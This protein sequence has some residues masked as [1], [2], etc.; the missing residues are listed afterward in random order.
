[1]ELEP[2]VDDEEGGDAEPSLG[3]FDQMRDQSKAWQQ[4]SV[5]AYP[6]DD[7]EQDDA[8]AEP[9]LGS[10]DG[11]A[12]KPHWLPAEAATLSPPN[13]ASVTMTARA[14]DLSGLA[15]G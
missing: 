9:A 5:W 2:D 6:A 10:L 4:H 3:S 7:G 15:Y 11:K 14:G 8:D 12:I 13:P 1:M